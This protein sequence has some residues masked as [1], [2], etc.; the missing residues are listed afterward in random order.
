MSIAPTNSDDSRTG[1]ARPHGE[2]QLARTVMTSRMA[3]PLPAFTPQLPLS[4]IAAMIPTEAAAYEFLEHF[5]WQGTPVCPHCGFEGSH[6]FL[7]PANGSSRTTN[8]GKQSERRVWKC[9]A[10]KRQFSVLTGTVMHGTH[11]AIRTWVL[12]FFELMASGGTMTAR[13]IEDR[14]HV[15][16]KSACFLLH[17]IHDDVRRGPDASLFSRLAAADLMSARELFDHRGADRV[18]HAAPLAPAGTFSEGSV[19]MW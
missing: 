9:R 13:D 5:S 8:R 14:Y 3:T 16:P 19:S 17:R 2:L 10:C 6:V 11:V 12:V 1:L 7:R 4:S 18:E 15:S